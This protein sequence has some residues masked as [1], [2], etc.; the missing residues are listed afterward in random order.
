MD[1]IL[2]RVEG[3]TKHFPVGGSFLSPGRS[4]TAAVDNVSFEVSRRSTLGLVG[5]SGSGKSTLG[6][7]IL[8]L[9]KPTAGRVCFS[10]QDIFAL[11]RR[12]MLRLRPS[13][14]MIFQD[15][16][17][18]LNPRKTIGWTLSEPLIVHRM[19]KGKAVMRRILEALE[20]VGLG[21]E[22]LGRFPH[23]LSGGQRQRV[24][25]ARALVMKPEF[26]VFDEPTS[27]LDVS[28]Q[29]KVLELIRGVKAEMDLTCIFI[30]HD[31]SVVRHLCDEIAVMYLGRIVEKAPTEA[32]FASPRHPYTQ[33]LLSSI[34]SADPHKRNLAK[35]AAMIGEPPSRLH[36][37]PGCAFHPRCPYAMD[38]CRV[39][40]PQLHLVSAGHA[41]AC[42][43]YP[44]S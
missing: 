24:A 6:L 3:L 42:H 12:A 22:Y 15:P 29:A 18:S 8:R 19:F 32:L 16:D 36:R 14:Q 1:E 28:V 23:E 9:M 41:A 37:P 39:V 30:S 17:S 5:E 11:D 13:M 10:D 44:D 31:L 38:H 26:I 43:L 25:I 40:E 35:N 21:G 20:Q 2:L 7:L 27:A 33:A 34:P 4:H